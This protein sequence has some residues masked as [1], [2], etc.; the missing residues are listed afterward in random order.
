MQRIES[1]PKA[2]CAERREQPFHAVRG[3]EMLDR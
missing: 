1:V 2:R 3:L